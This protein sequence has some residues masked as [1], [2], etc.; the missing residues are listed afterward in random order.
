MTTIVEFLTNYF[1]VDDKLKKFNASEITSMSFVAERKKR[2]IVVD[3]RIYFPYA[4]SD[5]VIANALK[6]IIRV[7]FTFGVA[8]DLNSDEKIYCIVVSRVFIPTQ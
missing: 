2:F 6:D 5:I 4:V 1:N 8:R 3:D 7:P